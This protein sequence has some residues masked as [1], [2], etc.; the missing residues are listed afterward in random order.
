MSMP[1][2]QTDTQWHIDA[3]K[4]RLAVA[5]WGMQTRNA[6][7]LADK[8]VEAIGAWL[9]EPSGLGGIAAGPFTGRERWLRWPEVSARVVRLGSVL[10]YR[11]PSE[12][13][14]SLNSLTCG[15]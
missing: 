1:S 5:F 11:S 12:L 2:Q 7:E 8:A 15:V 14:P 3:L 4:R 9:D 6:D 13:S 10:S